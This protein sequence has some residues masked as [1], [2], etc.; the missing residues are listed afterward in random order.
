[1]LMA[2]DIGNSNTTVGVFDDENLIATWRIATAIHHMPDEYAML[3]I[4]LVTNQG[5]KITDIDKMALCSVVPT[6]TGDFEDLARRYFNAEA[7]VVSAG[8]K[9]GVSI[10]LENPREAG[11]DRIVNAAAAHH[12]YGGPVIIIDMGT[13]TTFDTVAASGAYLGGA[14]AV[15]LISSAEALFTTTSQLKRVPIARPEKA[16]GTSSLT[17]MQS[18]LVFGYVGMIESLTRRI[19]SELS[20]KAT[21]VATGGYAELIAR[22]T[23]VIDVINQDLTL[24]G[25]RLIYMMNLA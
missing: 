23:P 11:A 14:I 16:I 9:T 25:L 4:N 19:Q 13:A 2:I 8:V 5:L 1:M 20:D 15:G 21:V 6:L 12:L 18:G 22:E 10:M 17:A 7:L 3:L 24:V